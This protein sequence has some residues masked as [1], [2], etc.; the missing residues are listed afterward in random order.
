MRLNAIT[1]ENLEY[2][3]DLLEDCIKTGNFA[4]HPEC[5]YNMDESGIP[6]NPK[7][8]RVVC[9]KGQK[10]VRYCCS[11]NKSQITVLGCCSATGQMQPP[12]IIFDAKKLNPLW[13]QGEI[14]CTRYGLS[15][16]GWT[17]QGLFKG[18]LQE[19]FIL[20]A[21]Q[22]RPLLLIVDGYSSHYDPDTIRFAREHSVIIFCLPPHTTHEAQPLDIS[23]FGPLKKHWGSVCHK[24]YQDS[25]GR[26]SMNC[27]LRLG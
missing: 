21:V 18:W 22:G 25:P 10:K 9:V 16:K 7:P 6:L 15:E 20:H 2:Y 1:Q 5:I 27:F 23:F 26:I 19:H 24:F 12:F 13:T 4:N 8:P 11:S 3:F 17:D 14:P